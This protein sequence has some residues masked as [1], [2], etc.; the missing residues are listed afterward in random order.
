MIQNMTLTMAMSAFDSLGIGA[1]FLYFKSSNSSWWK[2]IVKFFVVVLLYAFMASATKFNYFD[3]PEL[4]APVF[5][6]HFMAVYYPR[7]D[8]PKKI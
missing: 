3:T 7:G 8:I 5:V 4:V 6:L 2:K 1:Y